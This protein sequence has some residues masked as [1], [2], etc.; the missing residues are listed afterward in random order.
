MERWSPLPQRCHPQTLPLGLA[1]PAPSTPHGQH[2]WS[3]VK[4]QRSSSSCSLLCTCPQ[5]TIVRL[6]LPVGGVSRR[7]APRTPPRCERT[8]PADHSPLVPPAHS[9]GTP[10]RGKARTRNR[11]IEFEGGCPCYL[12][13][14]QGSGSIRGRDSHGYPVSGGGAHLGTQCQ[15]EGLT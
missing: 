15:G 7:L 13:D 4:G 11:P 10:R 2:T 14:W 8:P 3:K 5:L 9:P 12:G 6:E 1:C